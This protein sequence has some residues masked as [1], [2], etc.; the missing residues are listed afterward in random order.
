MRATLPSLAFSLALALPLPFVSTLWGDAEGRA[1]QEPRARTSQEPTPGRGDRKP[2]EEGDEAAPQP[3][4]D[5]YGRVIQRSAK[6]KAKD[7]LQGCWQLIDIQLVGFPDRGRAGSGLMLVHD[8]FLSFELHMSWPGT[9]SLS[10]R[11]TDVHQ[12]FIAEYELRPDRTL[13]VDTLIGSFIDDVTGELEWERSGF[14]RQYAV[15][16]TDDTLV[17]K[18]GQGNRMAFTRKQSSRSG[19]RD[20]FGREKRDSAEGRDIYGRPLKRADD[21]SR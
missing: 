16:Q 21:G 13:N 18:F 8:G 9:G 17:L 5:I 14:A 6:D 3:E 15:E 19:A 7:S 2:K 12:S 1:A 10:D 20:I 11:G 4:L